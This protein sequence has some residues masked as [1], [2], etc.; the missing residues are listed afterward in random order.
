MP[1]THQFGQLIIH[2]NTSRCCF[3]SE[4]L[5]EEARTFGSK[6]FITVSLSFGLRFGSIAFPKQ[7]QLLRNW[8]IIPLWL[9]QPPPF[10]LLF[11]A[12]V[13]SASQSWE[14]ILSPNFLPQ[15][16]SDHPIEVKRLKSC[17]GV[18]WSGQSKCRTPEMDSVIGMQA[19]APSFI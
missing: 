6:V 7:R 15:Y 8:P 14:H 11:C 13:L 9:L 1:F 19:L 18:Q 16:L 17:L 12:G 5:P 2:H 3:E 4:H 10:A